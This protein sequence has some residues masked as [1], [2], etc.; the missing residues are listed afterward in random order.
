MRL[1]R[2]PGICPILSCDWLLEC[3]LAPSALKLSLGS[4]RRNS[5]SSSPSEYLPHS[6][7]QR[8]PTVTH[9]PG[10]RGH[11]TA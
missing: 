5:R 10:R 9:S 8:S 3:T 11:S 1:A 4:P 6:P 2:P 7:G